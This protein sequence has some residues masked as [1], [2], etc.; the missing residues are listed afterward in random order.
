[1]S[2]RMSNKQWQRAMEL[3]KLI[4]IDFVAYD[5]FEMAPVKEYDMYMRTF[6]RMD[7]KQVRK[8]LAA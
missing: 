1:M 7:T 2:K 5:M 3:S 6:G 4:D 8:I